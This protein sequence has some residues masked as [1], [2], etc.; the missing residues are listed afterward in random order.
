MTLHDDKKHLVPPIQVYRNIHKYFLVLCLLHTRKT[1]MDNM[2]VRKRVKIRNRY[3]Q[4]PP[5]P[6][7]QWESDTCLKYCPVM[8]IVKILYFIHFHHY[9]L[10]YPSVRH[11]G[12]P[13][14]S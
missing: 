12:I 13:I 4:A 7:Y 11:C 8:K 5:D 2:K 3:N 6:G 14:S 10:S 1:K 9:I